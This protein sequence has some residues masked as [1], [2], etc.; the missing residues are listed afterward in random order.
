MVVCHKNFLSSNTDEASW[1]ESCVRVS[2]QDKIYAQ[3]K[4]KALYMK[5]PD[6][7]SRVTNNR[8]DTFKFSTWSPTRGASGPTPGESPL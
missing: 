8:R 2:R 4:L 5:S 6:D 3:N 1:S 7:P